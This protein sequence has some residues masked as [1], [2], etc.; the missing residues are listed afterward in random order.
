MPGTANIR[1]KSAAAPLFAR[2]TSFHQEMVSLMEKTG[3]LT[4]CTISSLPPWFLNAVR[5]VELAIMKSQTASVNSPD[6]AYSFAASRSKSTPS[7]YAR[8]PA[9]EAATATGGVTNSADAEALPRVAMIAELLAASN[10]PSF[11]DRHP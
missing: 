6:L 11:H 9:P 8:G 4:P 1:V 7:R 2:F 10:A 5:S 3:S